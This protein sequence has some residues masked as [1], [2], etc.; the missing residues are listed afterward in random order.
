[1]LT[2]IQRFP[3]SKHDRRGQMNAQTKQAAQP[4]TD[5]H[6]TKRIGNTLYSVNVHFST[7]SRENINDKMLRL[8]KN[9]VITRKAVDL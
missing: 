2:A 6:F 4:N 9:E 8:I 1:M 5:G 7:T 3:K